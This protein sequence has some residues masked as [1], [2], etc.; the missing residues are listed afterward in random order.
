MLPCEMEKK[1]LLLP[2]LLTGVVQL[3]FFASPP[4]P[5]ACLSVRYYCCIDPYFPSSQFGW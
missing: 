3:E 1:K 2:L 5:S 4:R